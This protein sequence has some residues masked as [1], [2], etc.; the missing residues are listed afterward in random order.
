MPQVS[1]KYDGFVIAC[2][3]RFYI[4]LGL[5]ESLVA[6]LLQLI[7]DSQSEG[8]ATPPPPASAGQLAARGPLAIGDMATH[9]KCESK[10]CCTRQGLA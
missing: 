5:L 10:W 9:C 2:L 6:F 1:P 8:A 4:L 7:T 3:L